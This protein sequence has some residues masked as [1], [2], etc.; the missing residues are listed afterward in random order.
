M[1][2]F[3][4]IPVHPRLLEEIRSYNGQLKANKFTPR[5]FRPTLFKYS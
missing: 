3:S 4:P 2:E 5:K 1:G